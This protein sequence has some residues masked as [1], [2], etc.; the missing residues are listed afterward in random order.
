MTRPTRRRRPVARVRPVWW[1][2]VLSVA[3]GG[4]AQAQGRLQIHAAVTADAPGDTTGMRRETVATASDREVWVGDPVLDLPPSSIQTVGLELDADGETA[5]SLWLSDDSGRAFAALTEASVGRALAVVW[6]GRVL[7]APVVEAPILNGMVLVTGLDDAEAERLAAAIRQATDDVTEPD[8]LRANEGGETAGAPAR[9]AA[10]PTSVPRTPPVP[11]A[12]E[13]PPLRLDPP[14][15]LD[16]SPEPAPATPAPRPALPV[17]PTPAPAESAG[18]AALRLNAAVARRDWRAVAA[19]LHP[20]ALAAAL[21]DAADLLR[22]DGTTVVVQDGAEETSFAAADVLGRAPTARDLD[23]LDDLDAAALYLAALDALEVWGPPDASR[24]VLAEV[25]DGRRA[26]VV[27]RG[28][29]D[30]PGVSEVTVVTLEP[31]AG[32][33]WRLLLT[34][35]QGL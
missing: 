1:L 25:P 7:A 31:D 35:P 26:H 23:G 16:S 22:L 5:L 30:A 12:A 19:E 9:P 18:A 27:M 21:D 2:A 13:R 17:A 29:A 6:D 8:A 4:P 34:E 3:V 14:P 11:G 20:D 10:R 28:R 32:G 15:G 33:A 24:T